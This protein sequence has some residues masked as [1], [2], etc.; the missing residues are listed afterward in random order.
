MTCRCNLIFTD[1]RKAT[2]FNSKTLFCSEVHFRFSSKQVVV[3]VDDDVVVVVVAAAVVVI[4]DDDVFLTPSP[5]CASL[6]YQIVRYF[7][8]DPKKPNKNFSLKEKWSINDTRA[9][10]SN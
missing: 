5:S 1:A 9:E 10:L 3:V 6:D 2:L 8:L 7:I 4:V